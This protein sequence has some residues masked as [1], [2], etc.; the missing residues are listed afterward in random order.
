MI[1]DLGIGGL[2]ALV[3]AYDDWK[4]TPKG[5]KR[6]VEVNKRKLIPITKEELPKGWELE[7]GGNP[8]DGYVVYSNT[9]HEIDVTIELSL[10]APIHFGGR[11]SYEVRVKEL[12][13]ND[14]DEEIERTIG[15]FDAEKG[16]K[17]A[18]QQ[19]KD[20]ALEY[21]KRFQVV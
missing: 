20:K 5:K 3:K 6:L 15:T 9:E 2:K 7:D 10:S 17:V 16:W 8:N 13:D 4:N 19:A 21:M 12:P 18:A 14:D 1:E 11:Q